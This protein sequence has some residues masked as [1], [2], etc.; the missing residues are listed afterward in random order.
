M[1]RSISQSAR[2]KRHVGLL[3]TQVKL[4]HYFHGA[5][6]TTIRAF[7]RAIYKR[8]ATES[9]SS[10]AHRLPTATRFYRT[11]DDINRPQTLRQNREYLRRSEK[12]PT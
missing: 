6:I 9:E 11:D 10:H 12:H 5:L 2:G 7:A 4:V 1:A 3:K 8:P